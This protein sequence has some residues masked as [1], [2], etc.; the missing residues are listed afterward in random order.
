M[1]NSN[2]GND[3]ILPQFQEHIPFPRTGKFQNVSLT[4]SRICQNF[5]DQKQNLPEFQ[6]SLSYL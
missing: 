5:T 3:F 2:L 1:L 4:K 6:V